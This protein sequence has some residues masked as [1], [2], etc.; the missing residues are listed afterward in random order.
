[1]ATTTAETISAAMELINTKKQNLKKAFDELQSHSAVL[2][3]FNLSW[4]DL[5]SHF[6][7][8]QS[9][10]TQKFHLLQSLQSQSSTNPSSPSCQIP[11]DPS[12]SSNLPTQVAKDP[13]LPSL[14]STQMAE[15]PKSSFQMPKDLPCS[16]ILS[17]QIGKDPSSSSNPSSQNVVETD[18]NCEVDVVPPR[19]ELVA[20]CERMDAMGLRNYMNESV[21]NRNTIRGELLG[22]IRCAKDPAAMVLNAMEGF[23]C[24][25]GRNKGDKDQQLFGVRRSAVLLLEVLMGI[26]PNVGSEVRER[27]KKLALEWKGKLSM[28]GENPFE[29]LGFLHLVAAYGLQA[30]FKMDELVDHFVIVARYRQAVEL[31]RKIGLGDKLADLI[32]KLVSKGKHLL[33]V[34]FISEFGLTDKFPPVPILKSYVKES[35]KLAKKVCKDGNNSRQSMNEATAKESGALKSVIK[36]IEDLKLESE[37]PPTFLQK[38]LEQ[39]EKEKADRKRNAVAPAAKPLQLRQQQKQQTAK[40]PA[41]KPKQQLY[42]NKRP[43]MTAPDGSA[44]VSINVNDAG[45]LRAYSLSGIAPAPPAA[46]YAGSSAGLYGFSGGQMGFPGHPAP[47][48]TH[49]SLSELY[50]PSGYYNRPTTYGGYGPPPEYHPSY[51]P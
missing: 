49:L 18:I 6:T 43:R 47:T 1:M 20:F 10:L 50:V 39:L 21:N 40:E 24:V 11:K 37:Y 38:R 14:G 30:E 35:K 32:Q 29:A 19:P 28:D 26:S 48:S 51:Y 46:A 36:V 17:T 4:S 25:N 22:A 7:S 13:S 33:A 27:A 15:D 44:A 3:S 8:I 41:K 31:C 23:Y 12:P 9:S 42:G 45:L 5:D 16:S 2:S 34:K